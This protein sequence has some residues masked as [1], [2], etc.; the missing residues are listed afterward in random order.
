MTKLIAVL[1]L[2][3]AS[4]LPA[5]AASSP[6]ETY[7]KATSLLVG[8]NPSLTDRSDALNLLQ[9]AAED[10]FA[11]AQTALG[12]VLEAGALG[13]QDTQK[14]I[15]WY[16][17]AANQG[18]WIAQLSLGRIYFRGLAVP[19][20]AS[21]ARKWFL[22]AA[23]SGD[24]V[25]TYYLGRLSDEGAENPNYQEAAKW[26]LQAAEAGNPFAQERLARL[27]L[28]GLIGSGSKQEA[29]TWLLVSVEL[30][31]SHALGALQS[32]ESDIGKNSADA[33]R[34]EALD[35]R[36]RILARQTGPC[37]TWDGQVAESPIPPPLRLQPSCEMLKTGS[38][39]R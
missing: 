36:D 12:T 30:G 15:D 25:S 9:L 3:I 23:A 21:A 4:A 18:D 11:P 17:R 14:A 13:T 19:R 34:R 39:A 10:G 8:N 27:W 2:V 6:E 33:A 28:K 5:V 16:T 29:Y 24:G 35:I 1:L 26:Y 22:L 7:R 32:M 37:G 20:D 38:L 31:N